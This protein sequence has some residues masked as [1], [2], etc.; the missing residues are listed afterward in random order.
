MDVLNDD[1][2]KYERPAARASVDGFERPRV[3]IYLDMRLS[4]SAAKPKKHTV[5]DQLIPSVFQL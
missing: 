4:I 2:V 1:V 3:A 5:V